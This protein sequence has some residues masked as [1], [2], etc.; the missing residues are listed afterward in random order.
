MPEYA[1]AYLSTLGRP[2]R[3]EDL[4]AIAR[5]QLAA[6]ARVIDPDKPYLFCDTNLL[7]IRIW[8]EVKYGRCDPE[9][10]DMER[11]DRYA[12]HLLTYPDLPWE[13][14]PLRESPHRLR[15]LFDHYEA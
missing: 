12:L 1:R 5:G 13:P 7:V 3:E 9:I 6:E 11:L 2:Y 14:D 4:L 8:S 15:E 10:R